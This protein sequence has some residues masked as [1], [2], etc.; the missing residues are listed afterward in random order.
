M[1]E[2]PL[3]AVSCLVDGDISKV[4]KRAL[5]VG[6]QTYLSAREVLVIITGISKALALQKSIE[7]GVCHMWTV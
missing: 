7:E 6:V 5:T 4:P 1:T 3:T 2:W